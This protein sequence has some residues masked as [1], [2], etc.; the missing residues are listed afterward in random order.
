ML[1]SL[2][3]PEKELYSV[4]EVAKHFGWSRGT[5]YKLIEA[6]Q[7]P[8]GRN[9]GGRQTWTGEDLAAYL[10]LAGRWQP[11]NAPKIVREKGS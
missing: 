10:L 3:G 9:V 5:L 4:A 11:A 1:W 7:F 8:A 2:N 6:G